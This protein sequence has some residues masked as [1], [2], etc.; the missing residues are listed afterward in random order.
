MKQR[1]YFIY[2]YTFPNGK[3]YIGQTYKGS[4]RYGTQFGYKG[5]LVYRAMKKYPNYKKE[6]L[7]YCSLEE[8]D[9]RERFYIEKYKSMDKSFGYNREGGGNDSK[10]RSKETKD[11]ISFLHGGESVVQYSLDG[12]LIK[13]WNYAS[14]AANE[15]EINPDQ[16]Y[17]CCREKAKSAGGFLWAFAKDEKAFLK[18]YN[19]SES[20]YKVVYQFD[21]EGKLIKKWNSVD[22]IESQLGINHS[23]ISSCCNGKLKSAGGYI[24]SFKDQCK[25]YKTILRAKKVYQYDLSGKF[26]KEWDNVQMAADFYKID[27]RLISACCNKDQKS[28]HGYQWSY[29]KESELDKWFSNEPLVRVIQQLSKDGELIAEYESISSAARSLNVTVT[30]IHNCLKGISKSSH[31][32]QWRYK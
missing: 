19:R 20:R 4:G 14:E 24:W 18:K 1:V 17:K 12:K 22:E 13:R 21:K 11:L 7:E 28:A 9:D 31:G 10:I 16:I 6:I 15:L 27:R 3:V 8:V 23:S 2:K 29:L 32:Y 5:Q 26:I 25:A 30:S